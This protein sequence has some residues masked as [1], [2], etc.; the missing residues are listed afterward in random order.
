MIQFIFIHVQNTQD[1][2]IFQVDNAAT[3]DKLVQADNAA[4][5][6]K[7]VQVD[8]A[9]TPFLPAGQGSM[10]TFNALL[11]IFQIASLNSIWPKVYLFCRDFGDK[12][13]FEVF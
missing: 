8:N 3:K 10:T 13:L 12:C 7:I 5:E 2:M 11:S 4:T 1:R 9:A 6:G